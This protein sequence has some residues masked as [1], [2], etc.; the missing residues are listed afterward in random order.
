M[1]RETPSIVEWISDDTIFPF[2]SSAKRFCCVEIRKIRRNINEFADANFYLHSCHLNPLVSRKRWQTNISLI[3]F[4]IV[5]SS[6]ASIYGIFSA[7]HAQHKYRIGLCNVCFDWKFKWTSFTGFSSELAA[8]GVCEC[9]GGLC[10][11]NRQPQYLSTF[12]AGDI[13]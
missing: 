1:L 10:C 3:Q 13:Q 2:S 12:M 9:G 11:A 8:I 7:V 5:E 6:A 4:H